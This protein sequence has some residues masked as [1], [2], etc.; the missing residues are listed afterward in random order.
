MGLGEADARAKLID[1]AIHARGWTEDLIRREETAGAIEIVDGK[2]RKRA[3][4]RVDYTLRVKVNLDT[5][6][7]VLAL[8]EA[9]A[10]D[11]PP[12]HGLEQG[13]LYAS[14]KRLDVPFV[15]S[16]NGHLFVEFDRFTGHTSAP[17]PLA[18]FPTPA[19]LRVRYEHGM[20]F[21]LDSP[22]ARPL[23]ARYAGGEATRRYYQDAAIRAVL[24]KLA[25]GDKKALLTLATGAG[26]TF[27]AVHLLKRIA[28]AGQLKRALFVC[29]CD[30][31]RSQ[32]LTTLQNVFGTDA[33]EVYEDADGKNHARIHVVT[34]QTLDVDKEDGTANFLTKHHPKNYFSHIIIDECHRSAWGKWSQVLTRN[35]DAVQIGLTATPRQIKL[36]RDAVPGVR[37]SSKDQDGGEAVPPA[38]QRRKHPARGVFITPD[39]PTIVFLTVCTKDRQ[40][41]LTQA[42]VHQAL[43]EVW[44]S[45]T[46]W[47]VGWYVLM[48]DHLHVFCAPND[49]NFELN[50]WVTYWKRQFSRLH[51]PGTG[52]WQ[53]D[54][55]DTRLRRSESYAQK[56]EYVRQNPVRKGLCATPEEWPYQGELNVLAW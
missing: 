29:D 16:S 21:T 36:G 53:R 44:T 2:P 33:A 6:P 46:V 11:L 12:M 41:W 55:W 34:Y 56:W 13:K 54:G 30:E 15:F 10:E 27:I 31:L 43:R 52:A 3:K 4:G 28:D 47:M 35:P 19:D 9:K 24:E 51:L 22:S 20:G 39:Q 48:P 17:K 25:R 5:Q 45:A 1:P 37:T 50:T 38:T 42:H 23:L 49:L 32:G 40:P 26:K 14:C 18:G 7:V 8:I